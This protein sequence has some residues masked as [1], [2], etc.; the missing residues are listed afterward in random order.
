MSKVKV[1]VQELG[2]QRGEGDYFLK[3]GLFPGE[4]NYARWYIKRSNEEIV[5]CKPCKH[6]ILMCVEFG[7]VPSQE[8][9]LVANWYP[10][11]QLQ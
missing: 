11:L 8:R 2:G 7:Y 5:H 4:Y 3:E 1:T 9:L 6:C 10:V